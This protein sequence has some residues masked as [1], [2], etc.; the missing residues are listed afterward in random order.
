M[1]DFDGRIVILLENT[2]QR[3]H[4]RLTYQ[5][6]LKLKPLQLGSGL[7]TRAFNKNY[8][9]MLTHFP[10]FPTPVQTRSGSKS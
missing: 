5:T 2:S 8:S 10:H 6:L 3:A 7:L 4:I 9:L 1:S